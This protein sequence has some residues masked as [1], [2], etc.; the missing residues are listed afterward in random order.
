MTRR[1][2]RWGHCH[3]C[4]YAWRMRVR[5]PRICPRCKSRLWN[6]PR[7]EP[8]HLGTGL[9]IDEVLGPYREAILRLAHRYGAKR[10]RVFGS[11]RRREATERSDVD[12]LVEWK[13]RASLLDVAGFQIG[14]RA[15]LHRRV[16]VVSPGRLHWAMAPQVLAEAVPL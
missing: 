10:V 1:V 7:I 15:L 8:I 4:V 14:V 16:D 12:L 9:G 11:V 3:R 13:P 2:V 6:V 5:F